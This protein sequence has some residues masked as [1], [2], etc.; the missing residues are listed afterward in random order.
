MCV[1][2]DLFDYLE[3]DADATFQVYAAELCQ[4]RKTVPASFTRRPAYGVDDLA[5]GTANTVC[6]L[7]TGWVRT[8]ISSPKSQPVAG[9]FFKDAD[10]PLIRISK[11]ARTH[12]PLRALPLTAIRSAGAPKTRSSTT[13]KTPGTSEPRS[14]A[15]AWSNSTTRSSGCPNTIREG[16]FGNWLENNV[17]WALSRERFWG[18]PLTRVDH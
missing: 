16:R 10:K 18:T 17:D 13:P 14:F 6:R 4:H 9:M 8:E 7:C 5:L 15:S 12:V 2:S 1:T 11:R 3:V